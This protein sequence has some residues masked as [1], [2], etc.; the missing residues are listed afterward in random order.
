[1]VRGNLSRRVMADMLQ[2]SFETD[3]SPTSALSDI[4]ERE[5]MPLRRFITDQLRQKIT[6]S[7]LQF[8][9]LHHL[10]RIFLPDTYIAMVQ[11]FGEEWMPVRD[12]HMMTL[13]WGKG[14]GKDSMCR[15][16][17]MRVADLINS[18]NS[19]QDYYG[20]PEQDD[21]H[22]LNVAS[23]TDQARRAF[24]A[25]MRRMFTTNTHM[26]SML[27]GEPPGEMATSIRLK[28]N[29]E[30]ISGNS[31]AD[32]QEGLNLLVGIADEISAFKTVDELARA[33]I[34]EEGRSKKTAEGIV[35]MLRTSA[36]SRFP[37]SFKVVQISYPRF[38]GDAIMQA[39]AR[40]KQEQTR[41]TNESRI[42]THYLSGPWATWEV[43]PRVSKQD[44]SD[45]YD[46][47]PVMAATMY[48]C[49]PSASVNR[50][51]RDDFRI[52]ETFRRTISDPIQVEYYWGLPDNKIENALMPDERPGWQVRFHFNEQV[53]RPMMGARYA[54]H[55]DMAQVGDRAGIAMSH[56]RTFKT[57]QV[58]ADRPAERRPVVRNDFVFSFEADLAT[59]APDG[60][61]APR[62]IQL[63]WYRQ[64][65]WE[66]RARRFKIA[67]VTF[68]GWQSADMIQQLK[69]RGIE[70][71]VRSVDRPSVGV[72]QTFKEALY[73]GRID[74]YYRNRVIEEIKALTLLPNGK[75]D[76][77][78]GGG[79]DESDALA[80]SVFGALQ[81]GGSEGDTPAD[82]EE[83]ALSLLVSAAP[84]A[85]PMGF[86]GFGGESFGD[87]GPLGF[88]SN[89]RLG[90]G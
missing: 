25:P 22:L 15:L 48:E 1:M 27:R 54:L 35:K 47:D 42:S 67:N 68:D 13:M 62:E 3:G 31:D 82:V 14:S 88:G 11:E 74:G 44:F 50:F 64:L 51:M 38:K 86:G 84:G 29:V 80:G 52:N 53:L 75:V 45:D 2:E 26:M 90:F 39:A 8:D 17:V 76:H 58:S 19:P 21:I 33:G 40:A 83:G 69:S 61:H 18:L 57:F 34:S 85:S 77:P 32:T 43:N 30:L 78:P 10:E 72:Y 73:D 37:R 41:A 7:E 28:K 59:H 56:V 6:L 9:F 16:G 63:R 4:F 36:R 46:D 89:P 70:S 55:G 66:L 23:S 49:R 12:V 24:F 60:T 79:K 87:A 71:R 81:V 65:I 20:L 5:P